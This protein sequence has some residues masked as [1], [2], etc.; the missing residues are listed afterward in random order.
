MN[1]KNLGSFN[2]QWYSHGKSRVVRLLW[3]I[4]NGLFLQNPL[5]VWSKPKLWFLR[6]FGAKIGTGVVLKPQVSIKHPW[7]LS[8][9]SQVW[10]GEQVWID[11]LA[12]VVIGDNV[13]ISQGALLLTGN[14][15]YKK[16]EFDLMVGE[17][18][19]ADQAWI[20][21]RATVCPGVKVERGAILT[22]GS[23]ATQNL[24]A[25]GVYQGNPA[26]KLRSRLS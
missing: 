10:I 25:L 16:P 3:I 2:N 7:M 26:Q 4:C 20:G 17:I 18:H 11:N 8:I 23:I 13:C 5:F 1:V 12:P 21:A 6:L 22:V 24:E 15:N 9:G 19:I 14:H